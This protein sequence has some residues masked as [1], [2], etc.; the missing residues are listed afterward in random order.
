MCREEG[1]GNGVVSGS[2]IDKRES[3]VRDRGLGRTLRALGDTVS[4]AHW[5]ANSST[6]QLRQ[7]SCLAMQP[8]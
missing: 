3:G 5:K 8:W 4:Y 7:G 1:G 2:V 6:N